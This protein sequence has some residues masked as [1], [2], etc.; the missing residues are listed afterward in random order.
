MSEQ[1]L[2]LFVALASGKALAV[3]LNLTTTVLVGWLL[4]PSGLGE[5][6][7]RAA[8]G[9]L[10]HAAFV[11]WTHPSTVRYGHEEWLRTRGLTRTLGARLPLLVLGVSMAVVVVVV[12]PAQWLQRGFGAEASDWWM[13]ALF[14]LSVWLAARDVSLF[15]RH[16]GRA[17]GAIQNPC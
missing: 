16:S 10:I 14:A 6:T 2:S 13:V 3:P 11:N 9:T 17:D 1:R 15:C 5:W 7:L 4:G 8:A 12:E